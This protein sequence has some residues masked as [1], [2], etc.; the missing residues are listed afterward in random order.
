IWNAEVVHRLKPNVTLRAAY[1]QSHTTYLF[2]ANP[3]T[4]TTGGSSFLALTNQGSSRYHEAEAGV[5]Y[6]LREHDEINATYIW[7]RTRGDLNNLGSVLIPFEQPVIRP[8]VY[9]ILPSDVPHRFV[10]WGIFAV[11]WKMMFSSLIDVHTGQAYS[12]IDVLQNYVGTP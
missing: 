8:N 5:H 7:S 12:N 3:F 11:F 4:S 9:G 10:T 2:E 1:L 6:I